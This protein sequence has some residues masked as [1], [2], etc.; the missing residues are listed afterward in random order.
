MKKT[1][2][3]SVIFTTILFCLNLFAGGPV[4]EEDSVQLEVIKEYNGYCR[5]APDALTQNIVIR[6]KSRYYSFI[7]RIPKYEIGMGDMPKSKDPLL[8]KPKIDFNKYMLVVVINPDYL[9]YEGLSILSIIRTGDYV[10]VNYT[11]NKIFEN[12]AQQWPL[13]VSNY[14]AVLVDK[15]TG[16]VE[17][18]KFGGQ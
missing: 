9:K 3:I 2:S 14:K 6:S 16:N 13:G 12:H 5:L 17:F 8:K 10:D 7:K 18:N 11:F 4:D 15:V 1:L